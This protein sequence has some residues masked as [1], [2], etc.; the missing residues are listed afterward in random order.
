MKCALTF[1]ILIVIPS[2][3]RVFLNFSDLILFSISLG[4]VCFSFIFEQGSL[5]LLWG[6]CVCVCVCGIVKIQCSFIIFH[7]TSY[8]VTYD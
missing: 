5:K 8:F 7:V 3:P 4:V 1:R 6:Q 2:Y